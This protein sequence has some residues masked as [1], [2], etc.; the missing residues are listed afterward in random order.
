M[1]SRL[2]KVYSKL[3][4]TELSEVELATQKVELA[5]VDDFKKTIGEFNKSRTDGQGDLFKALEMAKKSIGSLTKAK[6][7]G[8]NYQALCPERQSAAH[9][10]DAQPADPVRTAVS[11]QPTARDHQDFRCGLARGHVVR[12]VSAALRRGGNAALRQ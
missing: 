3:P 12:D 10:Y 1:K 7:D 4:K 9:R 11:H 6:K 5:L 8:E 2:E